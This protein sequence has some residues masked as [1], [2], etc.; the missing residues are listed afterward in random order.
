MNLNDEKLKRA[1]KIVAKTELKQW[2]DFEEYPEPEFSEKFQKEMQA[3][4]YDVNANKVKQDK[5]RMG[6]QYYSKRGIAAV[7]LC[8]LLSCVIMPEAVMAGCQRLIEAVQTVFREYTEYQF[9]SRE[10]ADSQFVP[11][12]FG[13]IPENLYE[14]EIELT[15]KSYFVDYINA[16]GNIIFVLEQELLTKG[17][18][19][20]YIADTENAKEKY[21]MVKNSEV[22]FIEKNGRI[23]FVWICGAYRITGQTRLPEEEIILILENIAL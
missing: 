14:H 18:D 10:K 8:F 1:A 4:I 12:T 15:E 2:S 3:L 6:W 19:S 23:Q 13:Y 22:Q 20:T 5:V 7:L 17:M 21:Y 9:D 11:L 16:E